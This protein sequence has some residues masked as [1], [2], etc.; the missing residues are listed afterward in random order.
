MVETV[1][2]AQATN[3]MREKEIVMMTQTAWLDNVGTATAMAYR[4]ILTCLM[5]VAKVRGTI[6][7]ILTA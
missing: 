3:A 5:T 1:A 4:G 6:H 2:V 7:C